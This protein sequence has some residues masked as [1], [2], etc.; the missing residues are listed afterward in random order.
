NCFLYIEE[1]LFVLL[2]YG[3]NVNAT[4]DDGRTAL[5]TG[6]VLEGAQDILKLLIDNGAD[7]NYTDKEGRTSLLLALAGCQTENVKQLLD[8]GADVNLG[9]ANGSTALHCA[10]AYYGGM[11][12][13]KILLE[14]DADVNAED[15]EGNTP[16]MTLI[17]YGFFN[18]EVTALVQAGSSVNHRNKSGM[19]VLM[20]F[21]KECDVDIIKVLYNAGADFNAITSDRFGEKTA[22]SMLLAECYLRGQEECVE[23]AEFLLDHGATAGHV[24]PGIVHTAVTRRH[25]TLVQKLIQGGL[26]PKDISLGCYLPWPTRIVSPLS[27]ALFMNNVRLS[28]H[29]IDTWYLTQSDVRSL[30]RNMSVINLLE[31]NGNSECASLLRGLQPLS[32]TLLSFIAVSTAVGVGHDRAE[33]I[34]AIQLPWVFKKRLLFRN[35]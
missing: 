4:S 3:A 32:L 26:A 15:N 17:K 5:M 9:D 7:V 30:S 8:L 24:N 16:L 6:S 14:Q 35:E 20:L 29:F 28:R 33:R 12:M 10:P 23:V 2:K 21:A 22:L 34:E 25:E 11:E 18:E 1:I 13:L 31:K 19:T 27:V